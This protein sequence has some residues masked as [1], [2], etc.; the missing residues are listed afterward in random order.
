MVQ[1]K[2]QNTQETEI[3]NLCNETVKSSI[4]NLFKKINTKACIQT[5]Y[6]EAVPNIRKNF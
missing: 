2:N 5:V 1:Y 4:N 3:K 6:K